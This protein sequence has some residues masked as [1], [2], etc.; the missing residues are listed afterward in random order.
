MK[1]NWKNMLTVAMMATVAMGATS[2]DDDESSDDELD[3]NRQ[4]VIQNYVESVVIPTYKNLADAS[5][6]LAEVCDDL[7]TQEKVDEAC[8]EWKAARQYWELSEAFLFGAAS[9]YNI[10]PHIDSWP[11][12]LSEL[13]KLL[14]SA[15]IEASVAVAGYGLWGFHAIEYVIF[16]DGGTGDYSN[17]NREVGTITENEAIFA[18]A[19]ADDMRDQCI[20]LEAS[21]AGLENVSEEKQAFLADAELEPTLNYGN[22]LTSAG[23]AGND[24]YKSQIDAFEEILTG[25][26][27]IANEV[28]N[29]KIS[30]PMNSGNWADVESP[31]SWNSVA[32]FVDN[33]RSVRNAYYGT[34]D[35][36]M[37]SK[38]VSSIVALANKEIDTEVREKIDEAIAALD[39]MP[40]PFR[41]YIDKHDAD[42]TAKINAAVEACNAL[43]DALDAAQEAIK[44]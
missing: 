43:V 34:L 36:T 18:K 3:S 33:I 24:K 8:A 9:D 38:S 17:R 42:A 19:V 41:N 26:S 20:R 28:G 13:D 12:A 27:D 22:M 5:I 15:D 44:Q 21:W 7:S 4:A 31:H 40:R 25:A 30:D 39:A 29:T 11:L 1:M 16:K 35:G 6:R 23:L 14:T 32:D 10:D 2:C 37:S